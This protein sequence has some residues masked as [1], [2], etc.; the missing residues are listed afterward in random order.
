M[1]CWNTLPDKN[2]TAPPR[3]QEFLG[4]A[5]LDLLSGMLGSK[6][7]PDDIPNIVAYV[8]N[9]TLHVASTPKKQQSIGDNSVDQPVCLFVFLSDDH[10]KDKEGK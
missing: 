9:V 8:D 6:D 3:G 5:L 1:S 10:G 7:S 4:E 2:L